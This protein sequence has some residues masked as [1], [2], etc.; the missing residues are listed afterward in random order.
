MSMDRHVIAVAGLGKQ[1][2]DRTIIKDVTFGVAAGEILGLVGANGGGKTTTLR[3]LAGLLRPDPGN[4]TLLGK[5]L[6]APENRHHL[7]YMTQRNA[8]YP[9]LTVLE[10]LTFRAAVHGIGR[11]QLDDAVVTYGLTDVMTQAVSSLSGGWARRVEFAA[12]VLHQPKLMLLDEPTAGLDIVTRRDMWQWI[13][14]LAQYGCAVIVSTHD[15]I[16][17]EQCTHVLLY[18]DGGTDGPMTP[19]AVC[20]LWSSAT[21]EDAI[22]AM[23]AS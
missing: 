22:F 1:F 14:A 3:I 8:L 21:L 9:D 4:G 6:S 2:A 15:L 5:P 10:N 16:E 23:A 18:R 11:A 13:V 20:A 7:G 17:A 19:A 12:S